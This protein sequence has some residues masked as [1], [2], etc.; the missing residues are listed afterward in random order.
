M[1][2]KPFPHLLW[3]FLH[4]SRP[5]LLEENRFVVLDT[6]TTG[7]DYEK[8]R[9]LCIG[10][11]RLKNQ[12]ISVQDCFEVYLHQQHYNRASTE[13]HGILRREERPALPERKALEDFV[14]YIGKD[15]LVAHHAAFDLNMLNASLR[16]QG[17]PGIDNPVLDTSVL[18]RKTVIDS[19]VVPK[20]ERYTLDDLADRFDISRKDRHTALGDAYITAIA[21]IQITNLLRKQGKTIRPRPY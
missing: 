3:K 17:M 19:P 6:E 12:T 2:Q 5:I 14:A 21:F 8:D 15:I 10:A 1:K 18:Y 16:R 7:F 9:I 20:K 11:L 4:R 13:I